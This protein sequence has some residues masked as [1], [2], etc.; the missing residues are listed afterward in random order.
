LGTALSFATIGSAIAQDQPAASG[1]QNLEEI[2]VTGSRIRTNDVTAA[3]P[4]TVVTSEQIA[5]T[6][7]VTVEQFLRKIPDIDFTSGISS[8]DNNGG[9]GASEFGIHNLGPARTLVLVNGQRFPFT[10]T[11][12]SSAAV[13]FNN[14]PTS[15]IDHIEILRN[16]AS[17]IYGADAIA[18]V[19]NVITLQ[20]FNGFKVD[21]QVGETSYGDGT[22]YS[23]S[24]TLGQNFDRGNIIINLSYDHHDAIPAADRSWAI[25]QHPAEPINGYA[26]ISSRV[27]GATVSFPGFGKY[28]FPSGVGSGIAAGNA[29]TLGNTVDSAGVAY[30]GGKLT[31]GDIAIP[32]AGVYF[33][34][35]P[36]EFLT[37]SLERKQANFSGHYDITDGI[38]V[39]LEGFYTNRQSQEELNPEPLGANV[40]TPKFPLGLQIPAYYEKT[41]GG[42]FIRNPYF[43]TS[44]YTTLEGAA[45]T[46]ATALNA[47]TRRFENGPRNYVDDVNTYRFRVAFQGTV[48]GDYNWELGYFYGKS[49][50]TY[51]VQNEVNF[52]HLEKLVGAIPCG[53]DAPF[54]CSIANFLGYNTLTKAQARY[55]VFDNTDNSGYDESVAYGNIAGPLPYLPELPGG[56]IKGSFGFEYRT[57]NGYD[58]PDSIVSQGD[59]VIPGGPTVGGYNIGSIYA[60]VNLPIFKDLPWVKSLSLDASTRYD[61]NSTFGRAL[62][63][64]VGLDYAVND[65]FRL[66]ASN[67]TGFRAPQIKELYG[68]VAQSAA[69]GVDPCATGG[70]F[71]DAAACK[72]YNKGNPDSLTQVNQLSTLIGGNSHLKPETS[73]QWN[74]GGVFT[75]TAVPG[76][77]VAIDY[78]TILLRNEI[79]FLSGASLLASCYGD[80]PYVISQAE[81]CSHISRQPSGNL[82]FVSTLNGNISDENTDGIDI[83]TSYSFDTEQVGIP[84]GGHVVLD[85]KAAYLLSDNLINLGQVTQ[86]AGTY[87]STSSGVNS[88]EPRWKATVSIDY[89]QDNWSVLWTTRYYGGLKNADQSTY[90]AYGVCPNGGAGDYPGNETAGLFFHDISV[91]YNYENMTF[92]AGVDNLFDKDPPFLT[93]NADVYIGG[94]GYD[95]VGRMVYMKTS[96]K[97]GGEEAAPKEAAPYTPPAPAPVTASVPHSYLVFF[98]FNK[99][100][101]T[102]QAVSIVDQAA[103]NAETTKVTQLTVTG[104]TDTVGSDAYNMR[105]SRRRAESVAA[106]LEK[107]GIPSS[108]IEIVAKGKRDL[109]VPTA[110]GVKEPQNRRVQIVYSGGPTS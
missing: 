48:F 16:G 32:G 27:T 88:G 29:Y 95:A 31:P 91:T 14:I 79:G 90:C 86:Q 100:D 35:L 46:V 22:N 70:A 28:Y 33:N 72:V 65:D 66:R 3:N 53:A 81:S 2:V 99:S 103:A 105:L 55:L 4:L 68:A 84:G 59:A 63:Y 6:D 73:Q 43:P 74:I 41:A 21:G 110:D 26:A 87:N 17:S 5:K 45:P 57:E 50:A 54:G 92:T 1:T 62:T 71:T 30:S 9:L 42:P 36:T 104:H 8:N 96:I 10:D 106:E 18:G 77:N 44:L 61:Y 97:F 37:G 25:D 11:Q 24:A 98:D 23:T 64:K 89:S 67:S 15:M 47:Y 75:P 82:G 13:D 40:F 56:A 85:G 60:E 58:N 80:V 52:D 49:T 51:Q 7:A 93:S 20:N 39:L 38:T 78:Y 34:Y 109:L 102:S 12:G 19:I 76:L 101:L 94:A 83:D 107:K 69:G 108:E